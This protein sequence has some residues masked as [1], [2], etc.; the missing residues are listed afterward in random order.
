MKVKIKNLSYDS[1]YY[2]YINGSVTKMGKQTGKLKL[3]RFPNK[4]DGSI[5]DSNDPT[6]PKV[7]IYSDNGEVDF[8]L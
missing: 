7:W 5:M 1:A 3:D 4:A 8:V 2:I 6:K